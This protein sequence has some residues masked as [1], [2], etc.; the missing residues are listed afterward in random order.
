MSGTGKRKEKNGTE[1]SVR[2]SGLEQ[3]RCVNQKRCGS[4]RYLSLTY[5]QQLAKK[6]EYVRKS[7]EKGLVKRVMP[8]IGM[9]DPYHYRN[10][11]TAVFARD[12][13]GNPVSGVYEGGTHHV[14]PVEECLIEDALADKII[15]TIRGM[16][17]S[18]K[19]WIY[20]ED[21]R[22]GLLRYVLVR[23]G[24]TTGQV[25]VVLV[26]AS[27]VFPSKKNFVQALLREHPE[28]TT[29]V[30]NINPRTDSLILGDRQQVLYGKGYIED[31]LC[32]CTFRISPSSFYQINPVQTEKLYGKAIELAALTGKE[33]VIDAYCGIG[34]IGLIAA[35]RPGGRKAGSVLSIELNPDAVRDAI[36]NAKRNGIDNVRFFRADAGEF[37]EKMAAQ[38]ARADVLFM[39]PPRSGSTEAFMRSAAKLGP[40]RI[41]YISCNPETLGRDLKVFRRL[42]YQAGEVWPVDMFPWTE[43]CEAVCLLTREPVMRAGKR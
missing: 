22:R 21:T 36:T 11:V 13:K 5:E 32:G 43:S 1:N 41:V 4:C 14:L 40:E 28:I 35:S 31:V 9:D 38:G 37:M 19:I 20:D 18:F 12:R 7:L 33:K 10:K 26:T 34:T 17:K 16:L 30:Q 39:D 23:R 27:P 42:G 2:K 8:V 3:N 6:E 24:F 15:G 25:M 29:V